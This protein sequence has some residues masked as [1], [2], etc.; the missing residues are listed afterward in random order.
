MPWQFQAEILN[1][2]H[3]N[4][5]HHNGTHPTAASTAYNILASKCV[6]GVQDGYG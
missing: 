5:T 2:T 1:G 6:A 4:G 3:H